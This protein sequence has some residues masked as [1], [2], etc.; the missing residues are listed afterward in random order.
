MNRRGD[1]VDLLD[2]IINESDKLNILLQK[3]LKINA[4]FK[5][6]SFDLNWRY[7]RK[8]PMSIVECSKCLLRSPTNSD[9]MTAIFVI[10]ALMKAGYSKQD[11]VDDSCFEK[12]N[13]KYDYYKLVINNIEYITGTSNIKP[14]NRQ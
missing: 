2:I 12:I 5:S 4:K 3:G 8:T 1:I 14:A 7:N 10:N 13:E 11:I 6:V 9:F